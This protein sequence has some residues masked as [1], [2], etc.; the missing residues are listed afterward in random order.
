MSLQPARPARPLA[1]WWALLLTLCVLAL[2]RPAHAL[3]EDD[4]LPPEAAFRIE[5]RMVDA[6]TVEVGWRIAPGYYMY[7]EQFAFAADPP[8]GGRLGAPQVPRGNVIYDPVFEKDMATHRE[9]VAVRIPVNGPPAAFSLLATSQ[10]CADAGLCYPP[11]TQ[12]IAMNVGGDGGWQVAAP[13]APRAGFDWRGLMNAN[14]VGLAGALATAGTWQTVAVFF[15]LGVLLSLTPCVLPMLPILSSI[16]VGDAHARG[17]ARPR[18]LR[19]LGLAATY[20]LGMSLVYTAAGVAA[21]LTGASLAAALQTPL[22]LGMFAALL[23]VLALA[24]FD[25]FTV[26]TPARWQAAATGW[27]NR[28]PGGRYTGAFGMGAISALIVGPCVAAPLAGALLYISQTSDVLLGALALFALA[29]GMGVTLLIAGVSAGALLPR[30]GAWMD[31]VKRFFGMLLLAVAWWMLLPV[32]PGWVQMAGWVVLAFFA[33]SLL[34]AFDPLDADA[35]TGARL[36]KGMGWVFAVIGVVQALGLASGGRDPLQPLAHWAAPAPVATHVDAARDGAAI[37]APASAAPA[38]AAP[39]GATGLPGWLD[40]PRPGASA[41]AAAAAHPRFQRVASVAELD[42]LIAAN[43]G[44]PVMLDFYA[45]W[46]VSCKEME[47]FTFTDPGVAARM[48]RMLL[49]QADVT[50]NN[51]LDRELLKRFRLFGP[52]GIIFFDAAGR[53]LSQARVVGFQNARRFTASLDRALGGS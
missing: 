49:V 52:P 42:A 37:P 30:A 44:R 11:Q 43:R 20:V 15:V 39:G 6:G 46:C 38:L 14:D 23:F 32:L 17:H 28:M 24:M 1:L 51:A 31:A 10:G 53:E 47:R 5:A 40:A 21:G 36:A 48:S 25:V 41:A 13:A 26:Q 7:T 4:F 22:V 50:A 19:G 9:A 33:A 34:R 3:S 8:E 2:L 45:D 27:A 29:W 35:S 12:T 16:L 18:R